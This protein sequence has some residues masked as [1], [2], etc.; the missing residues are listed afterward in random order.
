MLNLTPVVNNFL[1]DAMI[2]DAT[3][4]FPLKISPNHVLDKLF[5]FFN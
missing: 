1:K 4:D 3:F 5:I 2:V